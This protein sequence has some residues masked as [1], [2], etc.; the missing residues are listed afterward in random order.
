MAAAA[1]Q[2]R[3]LGVPPRVAEAARD[4]LAALVEE[5]AEPG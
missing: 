1:D 3:D 4:Q 2:L 5:A